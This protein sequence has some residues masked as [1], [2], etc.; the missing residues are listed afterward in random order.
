M[1]WHS[2]RRKLALVTA[3]GLLMNKRKEEAG[4]TIAGIPRGMTVF[5]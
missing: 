3:S 4:A 5:T 2:K 1:T